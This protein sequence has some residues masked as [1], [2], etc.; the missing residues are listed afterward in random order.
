[1]WETNRPSRLRAPRRTT[2]TGVFAV[3]FSLLLV[4]F[5]VFVFGVIEVAR[6]MYIYNTLQE[7]TRRAANAAA[8]ADFSSNSALS[9]IKQNAVF[10]D[11]PGELLLA[12]PVS[13]QSVRIDYLALNRAPDGSTSIVEIAKNALPSCTA[14]NRQTCMADP[15]ALNCVRFVR[16]RVCDPSNSTSC[17]AV[18][19]QP[20]SLFV[21]LAVKL[22]TAPTIVPAE[23]LGFLP[24]AAACL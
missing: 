17:D 3:E 20:L 5:F 12:S 9:T 19:F 24:G 2:Q 7:V 23:S 10:R 18:G 6:M 1:M 16:A 11:S 8:S 13:D 21:D 4:V 15:N 22:P 14:Q